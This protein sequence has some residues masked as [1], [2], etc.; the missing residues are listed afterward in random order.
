M[1]DATTGILILTAFSIGFLHTILG[2]D[3]YIPFVAIAR[4]SNWSTKKTVWVTALCGVGHVSG[5]LVIGSIGILLG[6]M[7]MRLQLIESFRGEWAA[8]LLIGFGLAYLGWGVVQA[9]REVPHVHWHAHAEGT[10][11]SHLHR[12]DT[13]HCHVHDQF[14]ITPTEGQ[15][16][17]SITPWVLFLIFV[18]G[19]CEALIPLLMVPIASS[20]YFTMAAVVVA[21]ATATIGTMLVTVILILNGLKLI[22]FPNLHRYSHALAGC[23]ILFCGVLIKFGW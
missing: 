21:F 3:H 16:R 22:A 17:R 20:S 23:A 8:W 4:S 2:P 14:Q 13:D 6:T 10:I 19:P 12:H 15:T 5:S 11:H 18:F 9:V 1:V 7:L